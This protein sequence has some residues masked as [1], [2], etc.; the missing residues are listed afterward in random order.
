MAFL[1][2]PREC[3]LDNESQPHISIK[4]GGFEHAAADLAINVRQALKV[5]RLKQQKGKVRFSRMPQTELARAAGRSRDTLQ[6]SIGGSDDVEG[7][8]FPNP[9]LKTLCAIAGALGIPPAMLLMGPADWAA[10]LGVV[11]SLLQAKPGS[12]PRPDEIP[13]DEDGFAAVVVSV[14]QSLGL[15]QRLPETPEDEITPADRQT[16]NVI[17]ESWRRAAVGAVVASR[18]GSPTLAASQSRL[19]FALLGVALSKGAAKYKA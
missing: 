14:S 3:M 10:L 4:A 7:G 11:D 1:V 17:Y 9:N 5:S 2:L 16:V 6:R 18:I 15:L 12:L 19:Y 13:E 8:A